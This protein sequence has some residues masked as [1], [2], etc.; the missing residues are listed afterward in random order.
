MILLFYLI[1]YIS[2]KFREHKLV[3][4]CSGPKP[5]PLIGNLN[6]LLGDMKDITHKIIKLS[7]IYSSPWLLWVG[8]KLVV[9]LDD[10]EN[11][12]ILSNSSSGYEKSSLYFPMKNALGDGLLLHQTIA[13]ENTS[14]W[15]IHQKILSPVFKEVSTYMDSMIKNSNRLA[16]I[17]ET[18]NGKNVDIM[19]YVHLCTLDIIYDS[20]L[21]SDLNLQSNPDCK[22][23][24]YMSEAMT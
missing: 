2:D 9:I 21:E 17:L 8:P 13:N 16:N 4:K 10:P 14:I 6:V 11:I 18:T 5:Y 24:E 20:L 15:D 12:E 19:H 22:Y 23:D 1:K 3:K 7:T